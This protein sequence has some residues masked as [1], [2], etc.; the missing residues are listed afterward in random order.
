[1]S[2]RRTRDIS[3]RWVIVIGGFVITALTTGIAYNCWSLFTIP[4]CESLSVSRE[5]FSRLYSCLLFGQMISS[6]AFGRVTHRLGCTRYM[7]LSC[8]VL[9]LLI[10]LPAFV[11]QL[12]A[13]YATGF[14][15]GLFLSGASFLMFSVV[16]SNWFVKDCGLMTGIVMMSSGAVSAVLLPAVS[17]LI[18]A[19]GWRTTM[20]CLA[21]G[22]ALLTLPLALFFVTATPEERGLTAYGSGERQKTGGTEPAGTDTAKDTYEAAPRE[23][24]RTPSFRLLI[25]YVLGLFFIAS[26][27]ATSVPFLCDVGYSSAFAANV[28]AAGMAALAVFRITGGRAADRFGTNTAAVTVAA[29][30]PLLLAGLLWSV[31]TPYAAVFIAVGHGMEQTESAVCLPLLIRTMFGRKHYAENYGIV[32]GIGCMISA[33]IPL[34]YGRLYSVYGSYRPSYVICL[35]LYVFCFAGLLGAIRRGKRRRAKTPV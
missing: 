34:V 30:S 1:M 5:A 35:I 28:Q 26:L 6:L 25:F 4:Y 2:E 14:G 31:R 8:A 17:R 32:K 13:L 33:S 11:K 9:P 3:Y 22:L 7:R 24:L 16:I 12:W 20:L 21:A 18:E 10:A 15:I 23:M 19:L 27:N 29:L